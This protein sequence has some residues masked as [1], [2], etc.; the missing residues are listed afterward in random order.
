MVG[1]PFPKSPELVVELVE[2]WGFWR[3]LG[4]VKGNSLKLKI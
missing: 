3:R 1:F 4:W 2:T